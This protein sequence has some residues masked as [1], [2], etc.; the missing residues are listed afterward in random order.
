VGGA[1]EQLSGSVAVGHLVSNPLGNPRKVNWD[2]IRHAQYRP[3]VNATAF[4]DAMN[5][6]VSE[7]VLWRNRSGE[8]AESS[9]RRFDMDVAMR[10]HAEVL[11]AV[12]WGAPVS[13]DATVGS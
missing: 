9:R 3:Q 8:I 7:R 10:R 5:D 1:R 6:L 12:V 13:A 2:S 11:R 4:A